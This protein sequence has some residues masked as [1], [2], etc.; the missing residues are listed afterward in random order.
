MVEPERTSPAA[1]T[2]GTLVSIIIRE[3]LIGQ[4]SPPD[5]ADPVRIN[6]FSSSCRQPLSQWVLGTA[7]NIKKR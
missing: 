5:T 7:P 6:P 2:P 4:S 3:R 1:N